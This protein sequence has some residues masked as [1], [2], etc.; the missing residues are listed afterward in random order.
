MCQIM[1]EGLTAGL[2][3]GLKRAARPAGTTLLGNKG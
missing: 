2:S 3:E 1:Y